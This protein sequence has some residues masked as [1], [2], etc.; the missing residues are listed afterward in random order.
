MASYNTGKRFS[1][2]NAV[3]NSLPAGTVLEVVKAGNSYSQA[4][5]E[6]SEMPSVEFGPG[7][8][9][10]TKHGLGTVVR[11]SSNFSGIGGFNPS[12]QLLYVA[13]KDPVVRRINK[14]EAK[15]A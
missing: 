4:T 11:P 14:S 7:D 10:R 15:A 3:V 2:G 5:L 1:T 13:D 12:T 9:I 8:R 6:I